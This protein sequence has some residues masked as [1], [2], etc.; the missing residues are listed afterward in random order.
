MSKMCNSIHSYNVTHSS[1]PHFVVA[2]LLCNPVGL[3]HAGI[4]WEM[5]MSAAACVCI[6]AYAC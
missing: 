1:L 3:A 5:G 4:L 6:G 2:Q